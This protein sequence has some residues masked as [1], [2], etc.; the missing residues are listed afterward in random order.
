MTAK[1]YLEELC[2]LRPQEFPNGLKPSPLKAEDIKTI[3][4][5]IG[6]PLP[7]QY[8]DYL[9]SCQIPPTTS[10]IKLRGDLTDSFSETFSKEKNSYVE[11]DHESPVTVDLQW[12]GEGIFNHDNYIQ[13]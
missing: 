4:S 6:Y 10:Y 3:E 1:D 8:Q 11:Y 13:R 5:K 9:L 7:K 2:S 12:G